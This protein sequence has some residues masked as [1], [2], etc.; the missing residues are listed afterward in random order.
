ME[1][2]MSRRSSSRSLSR[3]SFTAVAVHKVQILIFAK[4][5]RSTFSAPSRTRRSEAT[6]TWRTRWTRW[7]RLLL[8]KFS[9]LQGWRFSS[10]Y[11]SL[12]NTR[13]TVSVLGMSSKHPQLWRG[14]TKEGGDNL[15]F[16]QLLWMAENLKTSISN[17]ES[18]EQ[19]WAQHIQHCDQLSLSSIS[20]Y[21]LLT[22]YKQCIN[23]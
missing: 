8:R 9:K 5:F 2:R 15:Q 7:G 13:V 10:S 12:L 23:F 22:R 20:I 16:H 11:P 18:R 14:R 21:F 3:S 17:E 1:V 4:I 6:P 19:C